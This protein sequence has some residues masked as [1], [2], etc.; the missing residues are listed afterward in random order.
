M[1]RRPA[2]AFRILATSFVLGALALSVAGAAG[3]A[4]PA[5]P[6]EE[7]PA[8]ADKTKLIARGKQ[9][10]TVSGCNDCHTP[11]TLFGAPDFDR[12]LAG[13]ELGWSGPWGTTYARN[14]TPDPETGLGY[15]KA[16]E[17][18][19]AIKS[20]KR[21]DGQP[22]LPPM[23]WQNLLALSDEDLNALA[24]Y[25]ESLPPISHAVPE[26]LPPGKAPSGSFLTFPAP[27]AWDAPKAPAGGGQH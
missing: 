17:I 11:G 21:L 13:S 7:K 22:M 19:A 16:H 14:L 5:K 3:K 10:A 12:T 15:Y 9:I 6:V 20:G 2:V 24:E 8:A 23:P 25:L 1:S 4:V 18:V 26:R 27:S